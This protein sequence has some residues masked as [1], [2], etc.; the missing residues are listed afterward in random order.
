MN[1]S[2]SE[3]HQNAGHQLIVIPQKLNL[4]L[5]L[6]NF[7]LTRQFYFCLKRRILET[8]MRRRTFTTFG[9]ILFFSQRFYSSLVLELTIPQGCE[10]RRFV[11]V[12]SRFN[13]PIRFCGDSDYRVLAVPLRTML[14]VLVLCTI[15]LR[16]W[17]MS[18]ILLEVKSFIYIRIPPYFLL[19]FFTRSTK[20]CCSFILHYMNRRRNRFVVFIVRLF[21]RMFECTQPKFEFMYIKMFSIVE[22]TQ[23][24]GLRCFLFLLVDSLHIFTTT[25]R[26][27]PVLTLF[28]HPCLWNKT[29]NY[30]NRVRVSMKLKQKSKYIFRHLCYN[31]NSICSSTVPILSEG[32][33]SIPVGQEKAK[34]RSSISSEGKETNL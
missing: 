1:Y 10:S 8:S 29:I 26:T 19:S 6:W 23:L 18:G 24:K 14:E 27:V 21:G 30:Y 17:I 33:S 16:L 25:I 7:T 12:R 34:T 9:S 15:R 11:I 2:I 4:S 31:F 13:L 32:E 3:R 28:L 22:M 5:Q 20:F